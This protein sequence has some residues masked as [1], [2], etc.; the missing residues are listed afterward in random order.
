MCVRPLLVAAAIFMVGA[1][2]T[3]TAPDAPAL[4]E[5]DSGGRIDA[6]GPGN[7][8]RV[9]VFVRRDCPIANRYAPELRR[10]AA[11]L[12][13]PAETGAA[14]ARL[15][16]VYVDREDTPRAIAGHQREY[17]L[18][19]PWLID[20]AHDLVSHAGAT[21]TPEAAVYSPSVD[22]RRQLLYRGRID[23]RVVDFGRVRPAATTHELRDAIDAAV[24][25]RV[26][27]QAGAPAV[28][29]FIADAR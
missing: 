12:D 23:D 9:F 13:L 10:L 6:L 24:H 3:A 29:C 1:V 16:L 21:V 4:L 25:G 15:W 27:R 28:G 18:R 2:V 11:G 19:L 14:S 22:G 26:P 5:S 20:R 7:D 17:S 8:V